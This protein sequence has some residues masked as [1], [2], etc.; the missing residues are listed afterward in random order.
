MFSITRLTSKLLLVGLAI[1]AISLIAACGGDDETA[2]EQPVATAEI[3]QEPTADSSLVSDDVVVP[4][5]T[6]IPGPPEVAVTPKEQPEPGSDEEGVLAG[7][8]RQIRALNNEDWQGFLDVCHPKFLHPPSVAQTKFAFEEIGG[9]FG[10]FLPG[11]T[12]QG[13]NAR[14]VEVVFCSD[15]QEAQ[16]NYDVYN[17]DDLVAEGTSR[18]WGVYE[19]VWYQNGGFMCTPDGVIKEEFL[20]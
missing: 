10:Y 7:L 18:T 4:T 15:G 13:Y 11:F 3:Q 20:K 8:E 6:A 19:G 1:L 5:A 17:Y 9:D 14:N 16:T 2:A 12:I